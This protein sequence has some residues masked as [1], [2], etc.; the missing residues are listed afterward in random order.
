MCM[1]APPD[2]LASAS[3][4]F[5]GRHGDVTRSAQQRG[6]SRQRLYREADSVLRDLQ[7]TPSEHLDGLRQQLAE[8]QSRL[9][10]LRAHRPFTVV[11]DADKQAEFA[12]TAQAEGVSLPTARRL[13][14]VLLGENTPSVAKLGRFSHQA[15]LRAGPLLEV[16]DEYTRP[17]T[18]QAAAD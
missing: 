5:F 18:R 12:A 4:V 16:F 17:R 2:R 14:A 10:M 1:V 11:L 13:L 3:A 7:P 8:L 6:V 15:G 9:Q